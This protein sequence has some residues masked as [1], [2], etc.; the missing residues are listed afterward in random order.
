MRPADDLTLFNSLRTTA[1]ALILG[2]VVVGCD[3][4]EF[5]EARSEETEMVDRMVASLQSNAAGI[6][7][8][9]I[10]TIDHSRLAEK[11]G[12]VLD[13]ST[14]SFYSNAEVNSRLLQNEIRAGLDLP[15]RVLAYYHDELLNV[16]YTDASFIRNRHGI[17]DSASLAAFDRDLDRLVANLPGA[18]PVNTAKLTQNYGIVELRSD[19]GFDE[20]VERLR[21]TILAEGD[22]TW[23]FDI[24]YQQ[25]ARAFGIELPR[26]SLLVFGAPA[27][28]AKAMHNHPSIGLDAFAQKLLVYEQNGEVHAIYNAIPAIA[29]LH[30][31]DTAIPHYVIA[32]RLKDTLSGAISKN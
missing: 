2:L 14:V 27:P 20:S 18:R 24:D 19:F 15:Y 17:E 4:A 10:T 16:V 6:D 21:D 12:A 26:A 11:E 22:T 32:F 23:F 1:F 8:E 7:A 29:R 31:E 25:Q 28:G 9:G 3:S 30:Y 13:A 5:S